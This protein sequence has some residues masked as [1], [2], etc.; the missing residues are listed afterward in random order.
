MNEMSSIKKEFVPSTEEMM[1]WTAKIFNQGIRLPGYP[2]DYWVEN[3][4]KEQ[5]ESLNLQDINFDPITVK[6]WESSNAKLEIW[7]IDNPTE[8]TNI[9]CFP[10]PYTSPTSGIEAD[11]IMIPDDKDLS[12]KI[13][14]YELNLTKLPVKLM[15]GLRGADRYYD[16]KNEFETLEQTVPFP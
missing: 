5:F 1:A 3:W 12:G 10:I 13:A 7:P 4:I 9:P 6:K 11:L 2:A 8:R 14:V 15:A 16:P